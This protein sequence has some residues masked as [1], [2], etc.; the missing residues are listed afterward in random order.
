MRPGL[1]PN[2]LFVV[3]FWVMFMLVLEASIWM[4]ARALQ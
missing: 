1:A 3:V 4:A 2:V